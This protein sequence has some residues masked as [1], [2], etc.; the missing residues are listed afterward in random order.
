MIKSLDDQDFRKRMERLERHIQEVERYADPEARAHTKEIVRTLLAMHAVGLERILEH[1]AGTGETGLSIIDALARD[2]LVGSLLLLYGLHPLDIET[3]VRHALD[4]VRPYLRFHGGS[5]ELLGI[6]DGVVRLR[7]ETRCDGSPSSAIPL[8]R[9]IEE[10][11]YEKAP[12]VTAIEVEEVEEQLP[13][14][15]GQGQA[16]VALPLVRG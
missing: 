6:A 12:D 4:K 11:V 9:A 3:R 13:A 10:A 1:V 7:M 8:K 5:V 2:D 16:R 15:N 14:A